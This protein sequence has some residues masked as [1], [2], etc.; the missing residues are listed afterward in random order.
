MSVAMEPIRRKRGVGGGRGHSPVCV[1]MC[2]R[3]SQGLEKAL[4]QVE[5]TQGSVWERMCILS[6]PT[7]LYSL[8]QWLQG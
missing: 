8:G 2:P 5:Q 1:R 6:A 3:S 7:L 4:P